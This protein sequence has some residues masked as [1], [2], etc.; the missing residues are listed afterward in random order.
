METYYKSLKFTPSHFPT[1]GG[2]SF[3]DSLIRKLNEM[4]KFKSGLDFLMKPL[5]GNLEKELSALTSILEKDYHLYHPFSE[6]SPRCTMNMKFFKIF[7][8]VTEMWSADVALRPCYVVAPFKHLP[9]RHSNPAT[10]EEIVGF[11][12]DTEKMIQY[13]IRGTN[14]LD[15]I[16][17]V[18]MGG[19]G[20]TTI[21]RKVYNCDNTVSHFDVRAW[22]I[23]SQTYNRRKLLQEILSQVT[24]SKDKGDNDDTSLM[25]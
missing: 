13:L 4:S 20:K 25:S 22:C 17:I 15:V 2:W 6:M 1:V 11:G 7:T 10:D 3:Q 24:S 14:E 19:Q 12:N 5:L 9:T 8:G 16:P 21:A 23:V 18:G